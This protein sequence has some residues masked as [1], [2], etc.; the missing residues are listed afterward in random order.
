MKASN[1][2]FQISGCALTKC[3]KYST[4]LGDLNIDANIN[5]EL[6][7]SGDFEWML[8][9]DEEAEHSIEMQMPFIA[10]VSIEIY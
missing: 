1:L 5:E 9:S 2:V 4:P 7:S 3:A 10:K 6:M 8:E